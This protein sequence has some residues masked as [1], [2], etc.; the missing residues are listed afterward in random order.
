MFATVQ[1]VPL[2]LLQAARSVRYAHVLVSLTNYEPL[3]NLQAFTNWTAAANTSLVELLANP[4]ML[5]ALLAYHTVPGQVTNSN[6]YPY[7]PACLSL[8]I[9]QAVLQADS[10]YQVSMRQSL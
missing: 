5:D 7:C 9:G 6:C 2:P 3:L 8:L 4:S 10:L 1:A